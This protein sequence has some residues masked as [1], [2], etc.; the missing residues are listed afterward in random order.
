MHH[1][2]CFSRLLYFRKTFGFLALFL[3]LVLAGCN[4]DTCFVGVIN[5]PGT[6]VAVGTGNLPSVCSGLQT[7]VAMS[8][9]V[10]LAPVCTGCSATRQVSSLHLTVIGVE[11][12]PGA[13]ADENSPDW[14]EIAPNLARAPLELD[15]MQHAASDSVAAHAEIPGHLPAGRYYQLRLRLLDDA[16][17]QSVHLPANHFCHASGSSC[18]ITASGDIHALQSIDGAHY[19]RVEVSS[20]IE[21]R[22]GQP[23]TL[24]MELSPEWTLQKSSSGAMEAAPLLR[25]RIVDESTSSTESF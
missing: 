23:N 5:A 15:L 16:S 17:S 18:A 7:P 2:L 14:Q 13:A 10:Q 11:L 12:H 21:V 3:F 20:P 4:S 25:G 8:L 22:A 24:R 6:G 19:M 1:L 9:A